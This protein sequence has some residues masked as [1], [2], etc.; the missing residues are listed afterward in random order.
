MKR[1]LLFVVALSSLA[2]SISPA[3]A[4]D[5]VQVT[6]KLT[7]YLG[8]PIG[9]GANQ[10]TATSSNSQVLSQVDLQ[11]NFS[12]NIPV[13]TQMTLDFVVIESG[14][15]EGGGISS[16]RSNPSISYW[17]TNIVPGFSMNTVVNLQLPKP[18][19]FKLSV[20]DAQ[21]QILLNTLVIAQFRSDKD[22]YRYGGL[23]WIS[24]SKQS[25]GSD[26]IF[27][28]SGIYKLYYYPASKVSLTYCQVQS[29]LVIR[30]CSAGSITTPIFSVLEDASY[31]LCLPINLGA[32]NST[33]STCIDSVIAAKAAA[34]KAAADKAAIAKTMKP[35]QTTTICIKGKTTVTIKSVTPKCPVGFKKKP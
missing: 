18:I 31:Q 15:Y 24:A 20:T 16:I 13:N 10:V 26:S 14:Y 3:V 7:N 21:S 2:F 11:G 29:P 34:D 35:A 23:S 33:P 30:Q 25:A 5:Y 17:G 19:E 1:F 9:G 27:S 8:N 12:F 6:G 22:N 4:V 28:P 32:N